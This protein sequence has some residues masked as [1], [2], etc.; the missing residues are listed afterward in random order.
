[1]QIEKLDKSFRKDMFCGF[2]AGGITGIIVAPVEFIKV[3]SQVNIMKLSEMLKLKKTYFE[4]FRAVPSFSFIFSIVCS[5]EFSINDR[6]KIYY[7]NLCGILSS[8]FTGASFL[9]AADHLMLR[10]DKGESTYQSF[11]SL[12]QIRN[13]AL[14]TGF[15]PMVA[16]EAIFILSVMHLGPWVGNLLKGSSD[17]SASIK[18]SSIGR[19]IT[20]I[21]TTLLSQPFDSLTRRMQYNLFK[22]PHSKITIIDNLIEMN[23]EYL[24]DPKL[25]KHPFFKGAIPRMWLATFGGV[26]AGGFFDLFKK[27]IDKISH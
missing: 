5:L 7:G 4:M 9:T 15:T 8:A 19:V 18:W 26:F 20:G 23:D 11:K 21:I 10:R 6:I 16:R 3:K 22:N 25:R 27:K 2:A 24:K 17:D 13:N 12:F 14:W 1:M